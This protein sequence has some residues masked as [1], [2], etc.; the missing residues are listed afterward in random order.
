MNIEQRGGERMIKSLTIRGFKSIKDL[1][2]FPLNNIN[3]LIGAN[4]SGKSN[5]VSYF[6]MMRELVNGRLKQ[7]TSKHGS[8]D[9]IV[10]FGVNVTRSVESEIEF[11]MGTYKLKLDVTADGYFT[12]TEERV[13]GISG[14]ISEK[15]LF[16]E[17]H[18]ESALKK[19]AGRKKTMS[20]AL[21]V[22]EAVDGW[23]V[24][25]FHDTSDTALIKRVGPLHD[26]EFLRPDGS[27]LAAFLHRLL[28]EEPDAYRR[29]RDAVNLALPFF[30]DFVLKPKQLKNEEHMINLMWRRTDSDYILW[31]SQL[32][33]GSLRFMCLAAAL[34]QPKLPTTII[35]DEPELGL[36]PNA[37][38]LL[39][40]LLKSASARTQVILS[41][42]S[43]ELVNEFS[44]DDLIIVEQVD[45]GTVFRRDSRRD[46]E[47][48]LKEYSV[49]ELWEKSIIG[50]GLA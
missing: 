19:N 27:N 41:T 9:R 1:N 32:S 25:H 26:D 42:Q 13:S 49:G 34:L 16:G 12:F 23:R 24:C 22:Y 45:E 30:D 2:S 4:G 5:F 8:A 14:G 18:R 35:I 38:T 20:A 44:I 43:V 33:D 40:A 37:I 46:F 10:S 48:W 7:W 17:C 21:P 11:D 39:A 31:P 3:V 50:G 36:H 47:E 29:V 6:S 15:V 28:D